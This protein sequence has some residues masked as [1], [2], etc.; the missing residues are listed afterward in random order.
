MFL[1][2]RIKIIPKGGQPPHPLLPVPT[3]LVATFSISMPV[4]G[5]DPPTQAPESVFKK[6]LSRFWHF[7]PKF[8]PSPKNFEC[9][10]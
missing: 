10:Q 9:I 4:L 2:L 1:L 3:S 8:T 6:P 7:R 5:C